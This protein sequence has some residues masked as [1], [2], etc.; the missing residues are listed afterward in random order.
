[1]RRAVKGSTDG[2]TTA[3][4]YEAVEQS[5]YQFG[6]DNYL[7]GA[8]NCSANR[9]AGFNRRTMELLGYRGRLVDS[10]PTRSMYKSARARARPNSLMARTA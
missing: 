1:M 10:E 5:D 8:L 3:E 2:A 4:E 6:K 7:F 9:F